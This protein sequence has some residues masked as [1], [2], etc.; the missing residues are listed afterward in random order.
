MSTECN[1]A[2][3]SNMA[4]H[5]VWDIPS[6]VSGETTQLSPGFLQ[7]AAS[8]NAIDAEQQVLSSSRPGY[9]RTSSFNR[10]R[11]LFLFSIFSDWSPCY[12]L[13]WEMLNIP[14]WN[15][16]KSS[17]ETRFR[18]VKRHRN[19]SLIFPQMA[20][21]PS[22][23]FFPLYKEPPRKHFGTRR[24]LLKYNLFSA[25]DKNLSSFFLCMA[26]EN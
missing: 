24:F 1:S 22:Q 19:G 18:S 14:V 9:L 23:E 13:P 25:S 7:A 10:C 17:P 8:H 5:V 3:Q 4:M 11:F 6:V 21:F 20:Y 16:W 15:I 12:C 26:L 2:H